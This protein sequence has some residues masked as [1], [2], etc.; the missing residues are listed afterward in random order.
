MTSFPSNRTSPALGSDR[1]ASSRAT[2]LFPL[3]LS[4]T[5]AVIVPGRSSNDT[6]STAW[7]CDRR[8]PLP[9]GKCFVRLRTSSGA[10]AVI[11][12]PPRR[13]GTRPRAPP[14]P[15]AA[16]AARSSAADRARPAREG[17]ADSADGSGTR[18]A[19]RAGPGGEPGI[20]VSGT[21]GPLSGG[22]DFKRPCVYGCCGFAPS[23]SAGAV[24]TI[25]PAY[26]IEIRSANSSRSDRSCVMKR[27]AKPKSRLS[28][29]TC[30]RISRWTTTSRAVVGSSRMISSGSRARA[31]AITTRWRMPPES[32]CG[33]ELTRRASMP[34]SSSSSPARASA[35]RRSI[36]SWALHRV[37][38]L[39]ADRASPD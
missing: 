3:P 37:H 7:T 2:V 22:K 1:C 24:S 35:R 21:S 13:D 39:I 25:S 16:S 30:W 8:T 27:T 38:E 28:A 9:S 5:S 31:M 36:F 10:A 19:G 29:S 33:Y 15:C 4:P 26:M 34:T 11:P 17:S 6:S 18:S 23:R 20:P 14:R 32:W 12:R